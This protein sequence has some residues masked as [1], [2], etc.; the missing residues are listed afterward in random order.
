VD[1][2]WEMKNKEMKRWRD[3]ENEATRTWRGGVKEWRSE[4]CKVQEKREER[5]E[6]REERREKRE[7]RKKKKEV[8][9]LCLL[10]LAVDIAIAMG[11]TLAFV[12][13]VSL[14]T[15]VHGVIY[16]VRLAD[17]IAIRASECIR[18]K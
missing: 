18:V 5:R 2:R 7:E 12:S 8:I 17:K 4:V 15:L 1:E 11:G 16:V 10:F 3:E 6:K 9:C 14:S 13:F